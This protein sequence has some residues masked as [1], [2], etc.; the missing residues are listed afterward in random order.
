MGEHPGSFAIPESEI[1]QYYQLYYVALNQGQ[2]LSLIER[3]L[4]IYGPIVVDMD[5]K[6]KC[7]EETRGYDEKLVDT[8]VTL[9][10][11]TIEDYLEL[12]T[13]TVRDTYVLEKPQPT[14]KKTVDGVREYKDG[15]HI[16]CPHIVSDVDTRRQIRAEFVD[17]MRDVFDDLADCM[18]KRGV[19]LDNDVDDIIDE[20]VISRNGMMMYGSKKPSGAQYHL[21]TI[22]R[23]VGGKMFPYRQTDVSPPTTI[24]SMFSNRLKLVKLL[25]IRRPFTASDVCSLTDYGQQQVVAYREEQRT[26]HTKIHKK[27]KH[28]KIKFSEDIEF[29]KGLVNLLSPKRAE[30]YSSWI[31]VGWCLHNI[32]HRLL[33]KWI[34]FSE[35]S[36]S[37]ASDSRGV[38][39]DEWDRMDNDGLYT[40]TLHYWAKQDSEVRYKE[41]VEN[42]LE[43]EVR[44]CAQKLDPSPLPTKGDEGK[45]AK[46]GGGGGGGASSRRTIDD[47]LHYI[48]RVIHK[49]YRH[50]FVCSAF[51]KRVW[52]KFENH[53]W[54][55]D[56]GGVTLRVLV[57]EDVS[58]IFRRS[59]EKYRARIRGLEPTDE[60]VHMRFERLARSCEFIADKLLRLDVKKKIMEE[61]SERF[62]WEQTMHN[63]DDELR[64]TPFE[65]ILDQNIYLIGMKNG[66]YDLT[67]HTMRAGR[68]E[69]YITMSTHVDYSVQNDFGWDYPDVLNIMTFFDQVLP[70]VRV[71]DYVLL[72]LASFMDGHTGRE[73]FH[74]WVGCGG[75]GKSKIIELYQRTMGDYCGVAAI[76]LLTSRRPDS[77]APTPDLVATKG[78]RFVVL[79]EPNE[80][81]KIQVGKM[82]ELTGG[83]KI[84]CRALHKEPIEFKPQFTMVLACN[85][86]PAVPADDGGTWRR[87]CVVRY[88]SKFVD[89][90]NP[91][92]KNEYPI[93]T[94]L[95]KKFDQW[96]KPFFWILT[97]YYRVFKDGGELPSVLVAGG[98]A[99]LRHDDAGGAAVLDDGDGVRHTYRTVPAGVEQPKEVIS[100]TAKY[101]RRNDHLGD[102]LE[103]CTFVNKGGALKLQ[104]LM[105]RY[106]GWCKDNVHNNVGI[107]NLQDALSK[108]WGDMDVK[109][110]AWKGFE[111][112]PIS[113]VLSGAGGI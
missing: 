55:L 36:S 9:L 20:C 77:N 11:M 49:A 7:S 78:R 31:E 101:K 29:V 108:R 34:E 97:Q 109:S 24:S 12:E 85:H 89:K 110:K 87:M 54:T 84:T 18:Q 47:I 6:F 80:N 43:Y 79:Q 83:D 25:S 66:V 41:Y 35:Q 107:K 30:S 105:H 62:F 95:S 74:V 10:L 1:E 96:T 22:Y 104:R 52:F 27:T 15:I 61:V 111:L 4:P 51:S 99:Y 5:I 75:N 19:E 93:D 90:P 67:T 45:G 53:R 94:E 76:T 48:V 69:D 73:Q 16:F 65:S 46:K 3:P 38:C 37:H 86:L 71:R 72:L 106:T 57:S 21:T 63:P 64:K 13:D 50:R 17:K 44:I 100:E 2:T 88:E 92:D 28:D 58:K 8:S 60:A 68:C 102:F 40:G 103:E 26:E 98:G 91:A 23:R 42:S 39:T 113:T 33:E 70:S 32:D 56:D 59:S 81:E 14:L 112:K 82:K